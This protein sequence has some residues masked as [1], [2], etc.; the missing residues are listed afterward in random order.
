M[1]QTLLHRPSPSDV[2]A[3]IPTARLSEMLRQDYAPEPAV[4][5]YPPLRGFGYR[6]P[7][8]PP[9]EPDSDP[10]DA[11]FG[12]HRGGP[13]ELPAAS[14]SGLA[15]RGRGG[16]AL[17]PSSEHRPFAQNDRLVTPVPIRKPD[18]GFLPSTTRIGKAARDAVAGLFEAPLGLSDASMGSLINRKP[19]EIRGV[20]GLIRTFNEV[21][22]QGGSQTLDLAGRTAFA[23]V[24]GGIAAVTQAAQE[25][26]MSRANA[27]RLERDLHVLVVSVGIASGTAF[28]KGP[29]VPSA[30]R[31][32]AEADVRGML[33]N[34][35]LDLPRN[36]RARAKQTLRDAFRDGK[37]AG[38]KAVQ[39]RQ[40]TEPPPRPVTTK[41]EQAPKPPITELPAI[42]RTVNPMTVE[43]FNNLPPTGTV[44]ANRIRTLQDGISPKF[45]PNPATGEEP[46]LLETINALRANPAAAGQYGPIR[47]FRDGDRTYS[48][49]HRR[50]LAHRLAG[51]P[52]RYRMATA[53][54]V[55]NELHRKRDASSGDG[56]SIRI[57]GGTNNGANQ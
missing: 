23:P 32:L 57:R 34:A 9:R 20:G 17:E 33:D 2:P 55:A 26:G 11:L 18:R 12:H 52:V 28:G 25:A 10:F 21:L 13:R 19:E 35:V 31:V 29:R 40:R 48:L 56:M 5:K 7:I 4:P 3:P 16:S 15:M 6:L 41:I 47:I 50:L 51:V 14:L 49:D 53:G 43:E 30:D 39:K 24:V 44:D 36:A 1:L 42:S 8:I 37:E 27:R 54:E 38:V 46:T 45:R 22:I